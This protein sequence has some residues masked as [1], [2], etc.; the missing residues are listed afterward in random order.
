MSNPRLLRL[1]FVGLA[2]VACQ[3]G[4]E[5]ARP[6]LDEDLARIGTAREA[7]SR[8]IAED[9]VDGIMAQLTDDHLTMP[10][11][12][13]MPPD[14]GAL[15]QWHQARIDA[16]TF[17]ADFVTDDVQVH[18]DIAIERWSG[19]STLTSRDG[20]SEIQDD[21]KGVWI[22]ERQPDGSWKL[23]WSIWNSNVG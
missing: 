8:A 19:A 5:T 23:L 13:P 2:L 17:R 12:V 15:R 22:W 10:P 16:Y 3:P 1:A 6:T 7:L 9:D 11:D 14:N 21:G 18:G 4:S 20:T